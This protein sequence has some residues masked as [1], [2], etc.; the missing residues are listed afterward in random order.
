M[1]SASGW[2]T[3]SVQPSS[4]ASGG[5]A[6]TA[7][8]LSLP[9]GTVSPS[10]STSTAGRTGQPF[11]PPA[12]GTVGQLSAVSTTPSPSKS[13]R[14]APAVVERSTARAGRW[15]IARRAERMP[16]RPPAPAVPTSVV[17]VAPG[18]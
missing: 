17:V 18:E 6:G 3:T 2:A 15:P 14:A 12:A 5:R 16:T 1:G 8:Q 9:L 13:D 4:S 10:V 11:G 7:G